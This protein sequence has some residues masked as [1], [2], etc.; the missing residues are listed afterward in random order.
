ME[1]NEHRCVD[2]YQDGVVLA[3]N[4]QLA[5]DQVGRYLLHRR[6]RLDEA[7]VLDSLL[8]SRLTNLALFEPLLQ[9][10]H[11]L[12]LKSRLVF[13]QLFFEVLFALI[14]GL[15][16]LTPSPS[17]EDLWFVASDSCLSTVLTHVFFI[18]V[19]FIVQGVSDTAEL[20]WHFPSEVSH[21]ELT[22]IFFYEYRVANGS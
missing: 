22:S 2:W 20:S 4:V 9:L 17:F 15:L 7:Q 18:L 11:F 1:G 21:L 3:V 16:A 12:S 14:L 6:V 10:S 19:I 8:L 13:F 5:L